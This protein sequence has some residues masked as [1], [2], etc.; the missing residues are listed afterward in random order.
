M[1]MVS[2]H[3]H[4]DLQTTS[5]WQLRTI[6]FLSFKCFPL[7]WIKWTNFWH[8]NKSMAIS[9][10][11][12]SIVPLAK[13]FLILRKGKRL[14]FRRCTLIL[15]WEYLNIQIGPGQIFIRC[16]RNTADGCILMILFIVNL[17]LNIWVRL[18]KLWQLKQYKK[19]L[20][21]SKVVRLLRNIG[22]K[23]NLPWGN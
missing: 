8:F 6:Q 7:F 14:W 20:I 19:S 2:D 23:Q 16:L 4:V 3:L 17:N 22:K 10:G 11:L 21:E 9:I 1:C 12:S 18:Y 13:V 5:C 15:C